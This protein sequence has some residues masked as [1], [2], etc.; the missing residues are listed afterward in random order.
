MIVVA[1]A[2]PAAD[3]PLLLDG[4]T[5]IPGLGQ[6]PISG[7]KVAAQQLAGSPHELTL[8]LGEDRHPL[9]LRRTFRLQARDDLPKAQ[10]LSPSA[11]N[12]GIRDDGSLLLQIGFADGVKA[13]DLQAAGLCVRRHRRRQPDRLP[14]R[15]QL[16]QS[17][18]RP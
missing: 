3:E 1:G 18:C 16:P 8:Q 17:G 6:D 7:R 5:P 14:H 4:T 12:T 15:A 2:G 10:V 13:Q 9:Q 11:A